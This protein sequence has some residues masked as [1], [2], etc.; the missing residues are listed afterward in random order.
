M[1]IAHD[2]FSKKTSC[3]LMLKAGDMGTL[4]SFKL[5]YLAL[6]VSGIDIQVFKSKVDITK[7]DSEQRLINSD[8]ARVTGCS[9]L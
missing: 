4:S 2:H 5:C 1:L 3:S 7:P 9:A 8:I 6:N